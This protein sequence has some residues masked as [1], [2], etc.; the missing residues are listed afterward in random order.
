MYEYIKLGINS[1]NNII[2]KSYFFL[3]GEEEDKRE[4]VNMAY[5]LFAQAV[6]EVIPDIYRVIWQ[7]RES[8][9]N[10]PTKSYGNYHI[11]LS[12]SGFIDSQF[13]EGYFS[14]HI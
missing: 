7:G 9:G 10:D 13:A 14:Y 4:H 6:D 8:N 12:H 11:D 5:T 3:Y 1:D 2:A